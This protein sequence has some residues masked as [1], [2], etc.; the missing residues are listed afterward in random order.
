MSRRSV[1]QI[2]ASSMA[3]IAFL[4]LIFFLVTT[5]MSVDYGIQRSLAPL[6]EQQT[7]RPMEIKE[8][9]F[10]RILITKEDKIMF[11][12]RQVELA[13][14]RGLVS[15]FYQN[16]AEKEITQIEL[17]GEY[18]VSLCVV[19]LL[20]E[21][22]A[23]YD[24]YVEVQNELSNAFYD[25]RNSLSQKTFARPLGALS[26]RELESVAT[27]VPMRLSESEPVP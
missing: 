7:Q 26:K 11:S 4:L 10:A 20:S 23:S 27:A 6:P 14:L 24:R 5:T 18:G 2:N 15:E 25:M 22:G 9:N 21:G 12:G 17:L 3:D 8:R 16:S 1:P 13:E 19:S